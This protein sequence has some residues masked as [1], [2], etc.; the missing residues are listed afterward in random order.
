M[1]VVIY[2]PIILLSCLYHCLRLFSILRLTR[3]LT[4]Q[5]LNDCLVVHVHA[6]AAFGSAVLD[7]AVATLAARHSA[8]RNQMS[9]SDDNVAVHRNDTRLLSSK[10]L[11]SFA[12]LSA[13]DAGVTARLD[14]V[15]ENVL[16]AI[17]IYRG[18][19]LSNSAMSVMLPSIRDRE[20]YGIEREKSGEDKVFE[21]VDLDALADEVEDL[22]DELG[23]YD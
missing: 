5:G 2:L 8:L 11:L 14:V 15:D 10:G 23:L 17:L 12:R 13:V 19:I 22:L 20:D 4:T 16:P 3:A 18:G 6:P 9:A 7:A 1:Y 21:D